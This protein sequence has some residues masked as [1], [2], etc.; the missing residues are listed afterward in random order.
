MI[1]EA[2]ERAAGLFS[3]GYYC[4]ESVL[5]AMAEAK[6]VQSDLIPRVATGFCSGLSR[7]AGLCGAV[8]GGVLGIGLWLGRNKPEDSVDPTYRTVRAFVAAFES[9]FGSTACPSV[10]G[11][12]LGTE[13]GQRHFK[14]NK[15]AKRCRELTATAA[16]LAL[17]AAREG[18]HPA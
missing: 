7:T 2:S 17:S 15:L 6:G 3:S 1:E 18:Q 16:R 12:D 10:I 11:C 8:S 14:Q 4:A 13:E 9:E 5:L